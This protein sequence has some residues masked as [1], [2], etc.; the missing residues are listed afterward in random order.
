MNNK[1]DCNDSYHED[2]EEESEEALKAARK[3]RLDRR[4][5]D[6]QNASRE[7]PLRPERRSRPRVNRVFYD[8][9]FDED[10]YDEMFED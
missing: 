8:P 4:R 9:D 6:S 1:Y 2:E 10:D 7:R 5:R 3:K